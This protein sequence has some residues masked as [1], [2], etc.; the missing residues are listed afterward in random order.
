MS[1][2][3]RELLKAVLELPRKDREFLADELLASLDDLSDEEFKAE[4]RRRRDECLNDPKV[5]VPWTALKR[6]K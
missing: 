3:G 1:K 2:R 6:V 5:S 4:L